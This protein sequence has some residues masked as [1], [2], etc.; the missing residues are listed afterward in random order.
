V[1]PGCNSA[2]G[3]S[4]FLCMHSS[5]LA[6]MQAARAFSVGPSCIFLRRRSCFGLLAS[7]RC[8]L[9]LGPAFFFFLSSDSFPSAHSQATEAATKRG[10]SSTRTRTPPILPPSPP[11]LPTH[12]QT[13]LH[14]PF[15]FSY[16]KHSIPPP[17]HGRNLDPPYPS[18]HRAKYTSR[19]TN[20][21]PACCPTSAST[22]RGLF[23]ILLPRSLL[24]VITAWPMLRA[25]YGPCPSQLRLFVVNNFAKLNP[26]I[27]AHPP[28]QFPARPL[29]RSVAC[30]SL[31]VFVSSFGLR[32]VSKKPS[33]SSVMIHIYWL[34]GGEGD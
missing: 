9:V 18:A 34:R 26:A 10:P 33:T 6:A 7:R 22:P 12:R 27:S 19:L 32:N 31:F 23:S 1:G 30:H 21:R 4:S 24:R 20:T 16:H 8:V 14:A 15:P 25:Y 11:L 2:F 17:R 28:E 5:F 13:A 29:S 3:L